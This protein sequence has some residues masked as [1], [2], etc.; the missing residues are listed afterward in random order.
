MGSNRIMTKRAPNVRPGKLKLSMVATGNVVSVNYKGENIKIQ[1]G[2][3]EFVLLMLGYIYDCYPDK[4]MKALER[5][6]ICSN[7]FDVT[8]RPPNYNSYNNDKYI[9]PMSPY[10]LMTN[11]DPS[12]LLKAIQGF[13]SA[14]EIED[15]DI[16]INIAPKEET[17][18]GILYID[19][20]GFRSDIIPI[21]ELDIE[22]LDIYNFSKA[23][24]FDSG[25][26]ASSLDTIAVKIIKY[27][28]K[29]DKSALELA[30]KSSLSPS[31]GVVKLSDDKDNLVGRASES[32]NLTRGTIYTYYS[33]K[34]QAFT[35]K[36][37]FKFMDAVGLPKSAIKIKVDQ[38]IANI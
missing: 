19:N 3:Q 17:N 25:F 27:A 37:I 22:K 16:L 23:F 4:F 21:T 6:K 18:D 36:F 1:G 5:G 33:N 14:L 28:A 34:S 9:I 15:E 10:F 30:V 35:I 29:K 2:W 24:I 26:K 8:R 32:V 31:V 38:I 13:P 7:N 12:A 20:I 11:M